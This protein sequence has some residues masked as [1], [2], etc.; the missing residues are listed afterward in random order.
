VRDNYGYRQ[1]SA[2]FYCG[3]TGWHQNIENALVVTCDVALRL[4]C[5]RCAPPASQHGSRSGLAGALLGGFSDLRVTVEHAIADRDLVGARWIIRGTH[6]GTY[7]GVPST[8]N[9]VTIPVHEIVRVR[10]R[11]LAEMW[12]GINLL[13]VA[14]RKGLLKPAKGDL[15][16]ALDGKVGSPY[17]ESEPAPDVGADYLD[18]AQAS[19][20]HRGRVG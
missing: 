17:V 2:K 16:E 18:L 19:G 9:R 10:D 7:R 3:R 1:R 5:G 11:R 12:F 14:Q 8:G 6:D 13:G 20:V 15:W 4:R